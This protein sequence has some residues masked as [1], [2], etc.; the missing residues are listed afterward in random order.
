[1]RNS[2]H[3]GVFDSGV[4]GLSVLNAIHDVLPQEQ[5]VYVADSGHAP[6]GDR[7]PEWITS[8][9][10]ALTRYLVDGGAKAVV[11]ACNTATTI[12]ISELRAKF[13]N[14]PIVAIE[15]A[16]KPAAAM[17]KTGTI[18]IMA[19]SMTLASA[20]F[21]KLVTTYAHDIETI[22]C[23][24]PGL[25]DMVESGAID[26]AE[27][28]RLLDR[29][30]AKAATLPVDVVALGCTHYTFVR[31]AIQAW[32]GRAVAVVDPAGAVAA[33]LKRRLGEAQL[34]ANPVSQG[35]VTLLTSGDVTRAVQIV[36]RL[37]ST[38][39]NVAI[40]PRVNAHA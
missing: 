32:W 6:Y 37:L 38:E 9:S 27:V 11:V 31:S 33:E 26:P 40:L 36:S 8:R 29:C 7:S 14:V 21:K 30:L 20:Q 25:A 3:I 35:S 23:P 10:I 1:M 22:A 28:S 12:A 18:A 39:A 16:V 2:G 17:T 13:P 24:C 4:G 15:P 19:T 34:L 5:L